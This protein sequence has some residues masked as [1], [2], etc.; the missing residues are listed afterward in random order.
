MRVLVSDAIAQDGLDILSEHIAVDVQTGLDQDELIHIIGQYEALIVRS[1]T[2]VTAHV[3]AAGHRL[4]VIGR[5]GVGVDNIDIDAATARGILVVNAPDGN[6]IAAAEHTIAIMMALA[7]HVARA[8]ASLRENKWERKKFIGVEV[9]GKTIGVIGMGRIGREVARRARGLDMHVLAFDPYVSNARAERIGVKLCTLDALL[10]QADFVTVHVPLTPATRGL[11]GERELTLLK[12]TARLI[13][14]ARGGII[15]ED[16]LRHA[17]DEGRLAGAALDVFEREPPLDNPLLNN[18]R[19]VVTP[20]LGASTQEAQIA[21]AVDV[22]RQVLDILNGK[23]PAHPINAPFV[24]PET[25]AQ[26]LPFCQ[27]AEKLGNAASQLV[28]KRLNQVRICYAG[29]LA[30]MDTNLLRALMIKGLLQGVTESRITLVNAN[31]IA[32]DRGLSVIE[33]KMDDAGHF[34]NLITVSFNDNGQQRLLSGTIIHDEPYIVRIDQYWM[35][36]VLR[37][38]QLLVYNRDQP[39][40]IGQVGDVTGRADINIAFMAVGRLRP[41]GDSL[42]VLTLDEYAPP[43]VRASIEAIPGVYSV[44]LLELGDRR[45]TQD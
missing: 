38:Y 19:V 13:N 26:L 30:D 21:V 32:R 20:H 16:A 7:R 14:C 27:L 3:I 12:P 31:L 37:G 29:Q 28:D 15:D 17:L 22:A 25:Q 9:T 2:Q 18:P 44:R 6:S 10:A 1:A 23:P 11:I 33:E 43:Q 40:T 35:D 41:R 8:D 4:Q 24:P 39:G 34:A 5:A 42:M 36:L 45:E